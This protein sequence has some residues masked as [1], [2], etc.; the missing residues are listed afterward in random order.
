[1]PQ[2]EEVDQNIRST[3]VTCRIPDCGGTIVADVGYP[4]LDGERRFGPHQVRPKVVTGLRC[5]TCQIVYAHIPGPQGPNQEALHRINEGLVHERK[6]K[7]GGILTASGRNLGLP[8]PLSPGSERQTVT[9]IAGTRE[10]VEA[11]INDS[12]SDKPWSA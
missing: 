9:R 6:D 3:G 5:N 4:P 1:M 7:T 11:A 12:K 10:N 2:T 8:L